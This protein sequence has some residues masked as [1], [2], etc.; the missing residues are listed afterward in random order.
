MV[1][2]GLILKTFFSARKKYG[3]GWYLQG[4]MRSSDI[5]EFPIYNVTH[6][7][8]HTQ[9]KHVA[10]LLPKWQD[11]APKMEVISI[12]VPTREQLLCFL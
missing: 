9:P 11:R 4:E 10:V 12:L 8:K 2:N 5:P 3:L 6:N 7:E 1:S